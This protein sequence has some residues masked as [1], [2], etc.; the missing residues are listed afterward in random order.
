MRLTS[1]ISAI[2]LHA[3]GEPGRVIQVDGQLG[4]ETGAG[5]LILD[6]VQLAGKKAMSAQEFVRGQR[7]LLGERLS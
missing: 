5:H 3:C 6:L 4:V 7:G 2:D 1:L